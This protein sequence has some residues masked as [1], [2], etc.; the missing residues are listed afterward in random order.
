MGGSRRQGRLVSSGLEAGFKKL[1]RT[2]SL[3]GGQRM[4][5]S[6]SEARRASDCGVGAGRTSSPL[7]S[8]RTRPFHPPP[9]VLLTPRSLPFIC[10]QQLTRPLLAPT[11]GTPYAGGY[12]RVRFAFGATY[13]SQP[14]KCSFPSFPLFFAPPRRIKADLDPFFALRHLRQQDLPP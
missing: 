4:H 3:V 8:A 7:L 10:F 12:F 5:P 13:P 2:G 1:V 14:P 11:D 6:T 9:F